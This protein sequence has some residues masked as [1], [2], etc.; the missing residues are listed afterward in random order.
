MA[1]QTPTIIG[2][3]FD[4]EGGRPDLTDW[5]HM[6]LIPAA[7]ACEV[8]HWTRSWALIEEGVFQREDLWVCEQAQRGIDAGT[9]DEML[10]GELEAAV[11]WFHGALDAALAI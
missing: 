1:E 3:G 9:T 7:R 10:F 4:T 2:V 6:M 8:D 5:D 11:R